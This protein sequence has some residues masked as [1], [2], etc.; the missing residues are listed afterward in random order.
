MSLIVLKRLPKWL[1]IVLNINSILYCCVEK[2][3]A[4]RMSLVIDVKL[5]IFSSI[6][7]TIVGIKDVFTSSNFFEFF[8]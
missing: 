4:K 2:A 8:L 7:S 1:D 5:G 3:V 6:I